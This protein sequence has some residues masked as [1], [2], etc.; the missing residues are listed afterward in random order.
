MV[1]TGRPVTPAGAS[2]F[3]GRA[4]RGAHSARERVR[5]SRPAKRRRKRAWGAQSFVLWRGHPVL[6]AHGGL[7]LLLLRQCWQAAAP[8]LVACGSRRGRRRVASSD[9]ACRD[10]LLD[11][12]AVAAV[13]VVARAAEPLGRPEARRAVRGALWRGLGEVLGLV[14]NGRSAMSAGGSA[15]AEG[16]GGHALRPRA[17]SLSWAGVQCAVRVCALGA[18]S[19]ASRRGRPVHRMG[20]GRRDSA[21]SGTLWP[22]LC[23]RRCVVPSDRRRHAP[24]PGRCSAVAVEV[25]AKAVGPLERCTARKGWSR[26]WP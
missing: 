21:R 14:P 4:R 26:Q 16:T 1:S 8:S 10:A 22:A 25:V 2:V 18:F 17:P 12:H 7:R 5:R 13:G 20:R 6:M 9:G 15:C 3:A 23:A 24:Q 11:R 19:V